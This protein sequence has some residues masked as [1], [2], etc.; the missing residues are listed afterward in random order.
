MNSVTGWSKVIKCVLFS[1]FE[2]EN[3]KISKFNK[4]KIIR[5]RR[6]STESKASVGR[7]CQT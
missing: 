6:S 2:G 4:I 1:S 3:N 5:K 7:L